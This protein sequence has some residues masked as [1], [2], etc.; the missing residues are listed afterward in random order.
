MPFLSRSKLVKQKGFLK[1]IFIL[2]ALILNII[3][4]FE[5]HPNSN[6]F[7]G[8]HSFSHLLV[9][10]MWFLSVY[11]AMFFFCFFV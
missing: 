9:L 8:S 5:V 6:S 3:K 2:N 7:Y 11:F 10:N 4:V 1:Y